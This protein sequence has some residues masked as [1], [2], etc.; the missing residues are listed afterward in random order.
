MD[1]HK[2]FTLRLTLILSLL[3]G[4]DPSPFEMAQK[5]E[6]LGGERAVNFEF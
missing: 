2:Y 1:F 5:V 3:P 6:F 4:S